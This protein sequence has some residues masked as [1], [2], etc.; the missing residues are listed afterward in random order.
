MKTETIPTPK[1]H[2]CPVCNKQ[3]T[4]E[5]ADFSGLCL[6][7]CSELYWIDPVGGIHLSNEK[8]YDPAAMYE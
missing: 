8:D 2:P 7:K 5:E 3:C 4:E 6:E 1:T